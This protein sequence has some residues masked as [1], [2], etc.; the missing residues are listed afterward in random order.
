MKRAKFWMVGVVLAASIA[1]AGTVAAKKVLQVKGSDTLVH[2]S[3]GWAENFM[4]ANPDIEVSV[5]GGGSGTGI[6]ALINGTA[7]LA[8]ASRPIKDKEIKLAKENGVNPMEW[9]VGMDGIGVIVNPKNPINELTM[10]QIKNIFTGKAENWKTVGGPNKGIVLYTR[11]S[12][13]GTF[14]FFQE[15]VLGKDDYS[16]KA[17]RMPSNSAIVQSVADDKY[18]IGY[19]GLGY[20]TEAGDRVKAL[21]V[22]AD[23]KSKGVEPTVATVKDGTYPISRALLVYSNGQPKGDVKEFVDFM[24][25]EAGQ[26]VVLDMGFVPNK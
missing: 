7:D 9:V 22:K 3:S 2:V 5:T 12:S 15:H 18:A 25:S 13:S 23:D 17:R 26:K 14:A 10:D 4:K 20:V 16:V 6:A 1:L 19:V 24:L 21:L 11:D 8:N